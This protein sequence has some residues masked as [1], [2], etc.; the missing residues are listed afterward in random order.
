MLA[1]RRNA[2][3]VLLILIGI[4]LTAALFYLLI[5]HD[6]L[7]L[8]LFTG[9]KWLPPEFRNPANGFASLWFAVVLLGLTAGGVYLLIR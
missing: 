7:I 4:H 6:N 8:P 1:S 5:R 9:R 3:D 2:M